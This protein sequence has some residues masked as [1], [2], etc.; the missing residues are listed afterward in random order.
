VAR[1]ADQ[2]H[3]AATQLSLIGMDRVLGWIVAESTASASTQSAFA[4]IV[5]EHVILDV[6]S[7]AE[8]EEGHLPHARHIPLQHLQSRAKELQGERVAVHCGTGARAAIAASVLERA[9]L[10][11]VICIRSSYE[12]LEAQMHA[13]A[14]S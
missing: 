1:S 9:C 2:A 10:E 7:D 14:S 8:W 12:E 13:F 6:R 11:D 3:A 4:P 5:R